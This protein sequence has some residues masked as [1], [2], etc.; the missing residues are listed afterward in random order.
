MAA[1]SRP[2]TRRV[3]RAPRGHRRQGRLDARVGLGLIAE[4]LRRH[5]GRRLVSQALELDSGSRAAP[6]RPQPG[7]RRPQGH[8]R[9][10]RRRAP[11]G[12]TD[13]RVPRRHRARSN[14]PAAARALPTADEEEPAPPPEGGGC[15][16]CCSS[17]RG[18]L[19]DSRSGTCC[20]ASRSRCPPSRRGRHA[21]LRHLVLRGAAPDGRRGQRR[22][23]PHLRRRDAGDS[24]RPSSTPR[25]RAGPHGAAAVDRRRPRPRVPGYQP[26]TSEVYVSDR[27]TASVYVYDA[28]GKYQ[29]S[30]GP[31]GASRAGSRWAWGS[32]PHGNL[33]VTD[34][35]RAPNGATVRPD[36]K[37]VRRSGRAAGSASPT[38][39]PSTPPATCTSPTATTA[40][41]SCTTRTGR[42]SPR[43]G[44]AR[45][46]A[47][48]ACR[49]AWPWT[50]RAAST[51][52]TRA[53]RASSSTGRSRSGERASST[54]D[55]SGTQ[56]VAD[57][58]LRIPQRHRGRRS[59]RVYVTDS[60]QRPR[61]VVEL[62]SA[63]LERGRWKRD[64][65][66][67]RRDGGP[68]QVHRS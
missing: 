21:R 64:R 26:A 30:F 11:Q 4:E 19:L 35:G 10:V 66:D 47:I 15:S 13:D 5:R 60:A 36:G 45:A 23:R 22:G 34:V 25:K 59:R 1:G 57:G 48:S 9:S 38:T 33:Y 43:S 8:P 42:S 49:A 31:P 44:G 16:C 3:P 12:A 27:P 63:Q 32:T 61:A 17:V 29:R 2:A 46:R 18:L 7:D 52:W 28:T 24:R 50:A 55:P 41:C 67:R 62:L 51:S 39:S 53:A 14:C 56:G 37:Q 54:S 6:A 68:R 20:S 58:A 40:G 65:V